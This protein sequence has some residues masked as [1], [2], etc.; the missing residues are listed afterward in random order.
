MANVKISELSSAGTLTGSEE[1]AI[2]QSSATVKTTTQDIANLASGGAS[3][4][5]YVAKVSGA[6]TPSATVFENTTGLTI[7]WATGPNNGDGNYSYTTT[8]S[9]IDPAKLAIFLTGQVNLYD[10]KGI[11]VIYAKPSYK[12]TIVN[13]TTA[14]VDVWYDTGTSFAEGTEVMVEFR[15][16]P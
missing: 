2:V 10:S 11:T 3:Y 16:Y 6:G 9:S 13:P 15:V 14:T 4:T 7:T 1:V 5:S 12:I 8:M